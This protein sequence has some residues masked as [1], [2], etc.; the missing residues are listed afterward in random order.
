MPE[1]G[2]SGR[3]AGEE[4][5]K[6]VVTSSERV[7]EGRL[8]KVR[9]DEVRFPDGSEG[10]REVIEHPGA[11]VV[12][13]VD[14]SGRIVLARQ[15]RHPVGGD[16]LE[17]PAGTLEPHEEAEDTA[18]RELKE[19]TGLTAERWDYLGSFFSSPG[20]LR[21]ELHA[22]LARDLQQAEQQLEADEDIRLEW[23]DLGGLLARPDEI[24]DAKTLACLFLLGHRMEAERL[25]L[26]HAGEQQEGN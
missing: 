23:R 18:A 12:A 6:P 15:Y 11:V 16:L 14:D 24:R 25:G 3:P 10:R 26:G 4:S 8:V 5:P 2:R 1:N 20:F 22:Y 17:L 9:V 7:F 21:E 13:A 19:E